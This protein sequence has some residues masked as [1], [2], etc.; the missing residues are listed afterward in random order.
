MGFTDWIKQGVGLAGKHLINT[1]D[2][3][4]GGVVGKLVKDGL[5]YANNNAGL[6]GKGLKWI[7]NK[8]LSKGT[9]DTLSNIANKAIDHIPDGIVKDTMKK[10]NYV[11]HGKSIL[12]D[13]QRKLKNQRRKARRKAY[14]A[15]KQHIT[16]NLQ[17]LF[18][19]VDND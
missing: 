18:D 12:T 2:A 4:T 1:A 10:I 5:N 13:E 14:K 17:S 8:Y 16:P 6:I 7:G 9:R 3:A 19:D 11:A 15:A